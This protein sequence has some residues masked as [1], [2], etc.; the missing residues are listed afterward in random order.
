M[1]PISRKELETFIGPKSKTSFYTKALDKY[2][3][4]PNKPIWCWPAALVN[5]FWFG[6]R[7]AHIVMLLLFA[8]YF[9]IFFVTLFISPIIAISLIA[10]IILLCGLFGINI[11]FDY[12]VKEISKIKENHLGT[13]EEKI[14]N[15]IE[16]RGGVSYKIPVFIYILFAGVMLAFINFI[17]S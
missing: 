5:L 1:E 7:N 9:S 12:A 14:L 8:G 11:Y 6:F 10:I 15:A 17:Q 2:F 16:R 13:S 4:N 3:T